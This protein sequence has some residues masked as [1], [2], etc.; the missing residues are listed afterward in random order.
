M[1]FICLFYSLCIWL[2]LISLA[3]P[4]R[5]AIPAAAEPSRRFCLAS[6]WAAPPAFGLT[7]G[8]HGVRAAAQAR[9]RRSQALLPTP[10]ITY[11]SGC[12]HTR[13]LQNSLSRLQ[14]HR[15]PC[16][17]IN[18]LI[19]FCRRDRTCARGPVRACFTTHTCARGQPKAL[20]PGASSL[21]VWMMLQEKVI[22]SPEGNAPSFIF[23]AFI[24][25]MQLP[26]RSPLLLQTLFSPFIQTFSSAF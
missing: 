16:Y 23:P 25:H 22:P 24:P 3:P 9:G 13:G 14:L 19:R 12:S 2:R 1:S 10:V 6:Y 20:T 8:P 4:R 17:N 15:A 11:W 7:A 26:A 5:P 18:S 21:W